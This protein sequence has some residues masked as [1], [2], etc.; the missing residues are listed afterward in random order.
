MTLTDRRSGQHTQFPAETGEASTE[1]AENSELSLGA[2]CLANTDFCIKG[3]PMPPLL[4]GL[5]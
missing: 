1:F 5:L 2:T 3:W 4:L